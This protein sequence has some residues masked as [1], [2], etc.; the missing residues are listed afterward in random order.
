MLYAGSRLDKAREV[1]DA[2]IKHAP[3]AIAEI[4]LDAEFFRLLRQLG[5][6]IGRRWPATRLS[7]HAQSFDAQV[8]LDTKAVGE[9]GQFVEDIL[10]GP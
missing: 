1:F 7:A 3:K 9:F 8:D 4:H 6:R 5:D 10:L 2:A